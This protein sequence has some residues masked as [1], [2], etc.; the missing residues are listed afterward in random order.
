M[1]KESGVTLNIIPKQIID[2]VNDIIRGHTLEEEAK[3][4]ET[5]SDPSS[6]STQDIASFRLDRLRK[7]ASKQV[8]FPVIIGGSLPPLFSTHLEGFKTEMDKI[9]DLTP[10]QIKDEIVE[11]AQK[12]A[13]K[14]RITKPNV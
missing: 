9:D 6:V 12:K 11:N 13:E 8:L 3:V 10:E 2:T 4:K 5:I 1:G 7:A 14:W